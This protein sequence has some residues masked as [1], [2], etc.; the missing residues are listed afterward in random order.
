[1]NKYLKSR[2]CFKTRHDLCPITLKSVIMNMNSFFR[3]CLMLSFSTL[4]FS[5]GYNRSDDTDDEEPPEI[6]YTSGIYTINRG[7]EQNTII[8]GSITFFDRQQEVGITNVF[9]LENDGQNL[10]NGV[11]SMT[12]FNGRGYIVARDNRR[13]DVV[14]IETFK[15]LGSIPNLDKPRYFLPINNN[16]AYLS[17]WGPDGGTG[18]IQVIDLNANAVI[19]SIPTRPGPERLIKKDDM[20]YVSNSGGFFLDSVLTKINPIMDEVVETIEVGLSPQNMV[21]DRNNNLWVICRGFIG[22]N[23]DLKRPGSLILLQNDE[24]ALEIELDPGAGNLVI[25]NGRDRMFYTMRGAVYQHGI[26]QTLVGAVPFIDHPYTTIGIDPQTNNIVAADAINFVSKGQVTIYN[27][28]GQELVSYEV[29]IVPIEFW[30][31]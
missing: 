18:S 4:I 14:D 16:K 17:Q 9:Q 1:M 19:K 27:T 31:Q 10:G 5:C 20:I 7:L 26:T 28:G 3:I 25:E 22:P 23:G 8:T 2:N 29:G 6:S 15:F 21:I 24:T 13:I 11:Q 12:V 30:F